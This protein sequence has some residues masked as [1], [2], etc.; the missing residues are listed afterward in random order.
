[1]DEQGINQMSDIKKAISE[2]FES[3]AK[4]ACFISEVR[5]LL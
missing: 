4:K 3:R 1:M 2:L 5:V